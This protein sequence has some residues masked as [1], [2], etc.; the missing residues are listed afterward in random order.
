MAAGRRNPQVRSGR[1]RPAGGGEQTDPGPVI[2]TAGQHDPGPVIVTAGQHDPGAVIISRAANAARTTGNKLVLLPA[3]GVEEGAAAMMRKAGFRV[4]SARESGAESPPAGYAMVFP[5]LG[6][7]VAA[8]DDPGRFGAL[9]IAAEPGTALPIPPEDEFLLYAASRQDWLRGYRDATVHIAD[10]MLEAPEAE[11]APETAFAGTPEATWGVRVTGSDAAA[12]RG[13]GVAIAVLDTGIATAHP[14]ASGRLVATASFIRGE[15]VEDGNG[16]GTHCAG[17]ASLG[18]APV[19]T[20][21][22]YG[23]AGAARLHVA[24]VLNN[25][26]EG[27]ERA[28]LQG[29]EWALSS[30]CRVISMSLSAQAPASKLIEQV[31]ARALARNALLVAAVGNDSNRPQ[32]VFPVG[33]PANAASIMGVAA[34]DRRLRVARFSNGGAEVD[35]AGPG[36]GVMSAWP[37]G[38]R[39][40][41][42]SG[43][44]MAAPFVAGIAAMWL[45]AV[46]SLTARGLWDKL[47]ATASATGEPKEAV[48][49][50]LVRAPR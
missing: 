4:Q 26:G 44:S 47:I 9:D 11:A 32:R 6:V 5:L 45:E 24:K 21:T 17:I 13:G 40:K 42:E 43:T 39:Y 46:P 35:I 30:G 15:T 16:H 19:G 10:R 27:P 49:A 31:G 14:D 1:G 2:V 18:G 20:S 41:Q 37:G 3:D 25:L 8:A 48:G 33:Y 28:I 29:I 22:R 38:R 50:G 36:V 12:T 34:L 23:A 7:A